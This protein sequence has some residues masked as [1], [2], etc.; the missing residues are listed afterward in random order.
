MYKVQL[1]AA[2]M[3]AAT[4]AIEITKNTS[5]TPTNS[6]LTQTNAFEVIPPAHVDDSCCCSV[7]PCMPTCQSA[8][9][10]DSGLEHEIPKE[11]NKI[12]EEIGEI[13]QPK[14]DKI[15]EEITDVVVE[16]TGDVNE[17]VDIIE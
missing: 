16:E 12:I 3:M 10:D 2:C 5:Q 9:E 11:V 1:A 7:N 14:I 15:I 4:Q 8:C 13:A 6:I 17:A